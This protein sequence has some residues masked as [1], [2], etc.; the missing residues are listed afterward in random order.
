MSAR[1]R[2]D[3]RR[4]G[5]RT[6]MSRP[7]PPRL[8]ALAAILAPLA[9]APAAAAA[10]ETED[11]AI[12]LKPRCYLS[13]EEGLLTATGFT[14]NAT[15]T[16]RLGRNRRLGSGSTDAEG[17]IRASFTAPTYRGTAGTRELTLTVSDGELSAATI[18]RMT[19]LTAGF[20]P[21]TGD[22]ATMRVRWRVLGLAPRRGVYVHY[23]RPNGKHR[24]TLRIGT[25]K[26]PCGSLKTG[27][28]ALFP[29]DFGY[30]RW[31][32]QVDSSSRYDADTVPRLLI[33]FDIEKP[34][35]D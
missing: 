27:P 8:L 4:R 32:F 17:R 31:T 23:V 22:P 12:R 16:A 5:F 24:R 18:L 7:M 19:P 2:I 30:G 10:E 3:W 14:P 35:D 25:A 9:L 29:F 33:R 28:I 20:S 1:C 34:K 26:S 6:M 13:G 21:R 11:P 15:W